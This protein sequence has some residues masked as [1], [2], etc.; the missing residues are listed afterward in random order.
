MNGFPSRATIK[1]I[2]LFAGLNSKIYGL[3]FEEGFY[4]VIM[5]ALFKS[6]SWIAM[7]M[8]TDLLARTYR[9]NVPGTKAN[10]NWTRRMQR[11]IAQL[12]SNRKEQKR[13]ELIR[14]LLVKTERA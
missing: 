12:G 14:E 11:S 6:G 7:V 13:M 3:D 9:F 1:K 10:L 8:I 4:P 2:A 5:E